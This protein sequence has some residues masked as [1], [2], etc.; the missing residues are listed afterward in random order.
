MSCNFKLF[1]ALDLLQ[2]NEKGTRSSVRCT[3]YE[4]LEGRNK[5]TDV[6]VRQL[7]VYQVIKVRLDF[8]HAIM[9]H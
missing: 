1:P 2:G 5:L 8:F 9:H 7:L 3:H 4:R 6:A